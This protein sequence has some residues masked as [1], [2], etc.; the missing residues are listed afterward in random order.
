MAT[1]C[2][3]LFNELQ[4]SEIDAWFDRYEIS[5][6]DSI[7]DRINDVKY[8]CNPRGRPDDFDRVKYD[9]K[10]ILINS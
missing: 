1:P 7:T 10:Y 9:S 6:G 5:P 8:I 4:K 3:L 2:G